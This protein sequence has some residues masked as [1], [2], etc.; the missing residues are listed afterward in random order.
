MVEDVVKTIDAVI[1]A[2]GSS[3]RLGTNKLCLRINGESVIRRTVG[4]FLAAGVKRVLVV[5]GHESG[6]IEKELLGMPVE[7]VEN[8]RHSEG[9][10]SSVKAALP[11]LVNERAAFFHLGDKPFITVETIRKM[12]QLFDEK[13]AS[14][15]IPLYQGKRGHPVLFDLSLCMDEMSRVKG[16]EGLRSV[17]GRHLDEAVYAEGDEGCVLDIDT[18]IDIESLAQRGYTVEEG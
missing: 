12:A 17:V 10:S 3:R 9:M 2:A 11:R 8:Q 16:D 5:A 1:L 15:V 18:Q 14:L 13:M 7:I 4:V 6:R